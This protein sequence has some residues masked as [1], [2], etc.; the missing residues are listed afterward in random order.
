MTAIWNKLH[1]APCGGNVKLDLVK[2]IQILITGAMT[3]LQWHCA[4]FRSFYNKYSCFGYIYKWFLLDYL[5][6]SQMWIGCCF[7]FQMQRSLY[8]KQAAGHYQRCLMF[9][10]IVVDSYIFSDFAAALCGAYTHHT[11]PLGEFHAFRLRVTCSDL[12]KTALNEHQ[13]LQSCL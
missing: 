13:D 2:R 1:I 3:I 10:S 11:I 8:H 4:I 12:L 7:R 6:F 5:I 9:Y